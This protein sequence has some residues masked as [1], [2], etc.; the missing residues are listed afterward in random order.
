LTQPD[1]IFSLVVAAILVV[2]SYAMIT[3]QFLV[4]MVESYIVV[5]A[6]F[7]FLGFDGSHWTAPYGRN[8]GKRVS[9]P[10][11]KARSAETAYDQSPQGLGGNTEE[12]G[13]AYFARYEIRRTFATRLSAGGVAD[14]MVTQMLRQSD[15]EVFK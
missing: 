14:H 2:I 9:V 6:G 5:A 15:V 7:I 13:I 1:V 4:A 12:S 11:S 3:I 10:Q 8:T